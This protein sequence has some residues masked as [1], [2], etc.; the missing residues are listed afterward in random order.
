M[1][2]KLYYEFCVLIWNLN[3]I[4]NFVIPS[5]PYYLFVFV[6]LFVRIMLYT[7]ADEVAGNVK[8]IMFILLLFYYIY[9]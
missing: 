6:F 3:Y 9:E 4:E 5:L 7:G 1:F 8:Q 2:E